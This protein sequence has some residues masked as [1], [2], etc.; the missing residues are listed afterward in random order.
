MQIAKLN[1]ETIPVQVAKL[2]NVLSFLEQMSEDATKIPGVTKDMVLYRINVLREILGLQLQPFTGDSK[3]V[4]STTETNAKFEKAALADGVERIFTLKRLIR[5]QVDDD[6]YSLTIWSRSP[7]TDG[8]MWRTTGLGFSLNGL[9][10][11][12]AFIPNALETLHPVAVEPT[13]QRLRDIHASIH[14]LAVKHPVIQEDVAPLLDTLYIG[15]T[16]V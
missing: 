15:G 6:H 4:I 10:C 5:A 2:E 13:D 16:R 12:A 3:P 11:L 14:K 7:D 1:Q 9:R 8:G